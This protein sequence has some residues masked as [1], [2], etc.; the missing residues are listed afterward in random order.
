M[1][2]GWQVATSAREQRRKELKK[3]KKRQAAE[4][5]ARKQE[6]ERTKEQ[7][8]QE[9]EVEQKKQ[10]ESAF[11]IEY[12]ANALTSIQSKSSKK[13][14][15]KNKKAGTSNTKPD[16]TPSRSQYSSVRVIIISFQFSRS[17]IKRKYINM[18]LVINRKH[19]AVFK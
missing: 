9:I 16:T 11:S 10:L 8:K 2:S 15:K 12:N 7:K 6:E 1:S 17:C 14:S 13:R 4:E 3:E 18:S 19:K 5:R